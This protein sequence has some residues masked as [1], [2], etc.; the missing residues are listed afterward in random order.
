[1]E[2][3]FLRTISLFIKTLLIITIIVVFCLFLLLLLS[4]N[5]FINLEWI[6]EFSNEVKVT[7]EF[8]PAVIT[9]VTLVIS[10]A[11]PLS[12]QI[13]SKTEDKRFS[14]DVSLL[15]FQEPIFKK[16]KLLIAILV[17]LVILLFVGGTNIYVSIIGL[18]LGIISLRLFSN[19]LDLMINYITNFS[20]V[21]KE[22]AKNKLDEII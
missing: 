1:M 16:M 14:S 17:F 18:I 6:T 3:L 8:L 10:V 21:L 20:S 7:S 15:L 5:V 13:A 2:K 11:L 12:I 19:F 22:K 4:K 9:I